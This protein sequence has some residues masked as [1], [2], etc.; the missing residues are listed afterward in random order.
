MPYAMLVPLMA[1]VPQVDHPL[2]ACSRIHMP[3]QIIFF[4]YPPTWIFIVVGL[5]GCS[6]DCSGNMQAANFISIQTKYTDQVVL[7]IA[8]YDNHFKNLLDV[9]VRLFLAGKS[10]AGQEF[11]SDEHETWTLLIQHTQPT[12][13]IIPQSIPTSNVSF[14][15]WC[16]LPCQSF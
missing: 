5:K 6:C 3:L 11:N 9:G 14:L 1:L 4:P 10:T 7:S 2:V 8:L 15:H 16:T 12:W 13:I